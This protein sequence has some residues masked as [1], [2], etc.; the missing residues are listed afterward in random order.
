MKIITNLLLCL[1]LVSC[2]TDIIRPPVKGVI[3]DFENKKPILKANIIPVD[4]QGI[5]KG[6]FSNINGNFFIP[7]N[8]KKSVF[9]LEGSPKEYRLI[10]SA[11][12]YVTD[13]IIDETRYGF[14][15]DVVI[16]DSIFLKKIKL[17]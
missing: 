10:I 1:T 9:S 14:S 4:S 5:H 7:I 11:K 8:S 13:T 16:F 2:S 3:Y 17:K 15:K 12:N 6:T